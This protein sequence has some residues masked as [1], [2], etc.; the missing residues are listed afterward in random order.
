[1]MALAALVLSKMA[2]VGVP[3]LLKELVDQLGTAPGVLPIALLAGYGALRLTAAAFN[4]IRDALFA[5]VR[6]RAMRQVSLRVL[7]HLHTLGLRYHLERRTGA[8]IHD[9]DQGTRSV[10]SLLN[11]L[12]F[13]ILPTLVEIVLVALILLRRYD[14][15]FAAVT[16]C[17]VLIYIA[18]TFATT[19]WRIPLRHKMNQLESAASSQAVDSLINYETVKY[20]GNEA[21]ELRRYDATLAQWEDA[22][23]LTQTSLGMLNAGQSGIIAVGVTVVMILAAQ[24]I[25][26][27]R[28]TLGDLILVNAFLIQLFIPLNFLGVVYSQFKHALADMEQMLRLLDHRPEIAEAP[29]AIT[30]PDGALSIK[31]ESVAFAYLSERPILYDIDFSIPVGSK[32]AVVGASGSGKSTLARLLFRFYDVQS[33]RISIN[34]IDIRDL[35][36]ESLRAA[37]AIVPQDTVLFNETIYYNIAYGRPNATRVEIEHAAKLAHLQDFV[38]T[39]P[40]GYETIVGERGLKLSGGEKQRVAIARAILK[41]PRILIF[42]EATSSLD[43]HSEQIILTALAEVATQRTTL[44]IAHRLSTIM[45]ADQILVMDAGRITERGTHSELLARGGLYAYLWNLQQEERKP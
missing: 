35:Q 38:L 18:F 37:I 4:E 9:I 43:S 25:N 14:P 7:S 10:S 12:A 41:S 20:F 42:D 39:L 26:S 13:S 24:G 2:N 31:F 5:R 11:Y 40:Q 15:E 17:A 1:M 8:L 3:L 45:D 36:Q 30:L 22:A 6:H 19:N 21:H 34:G 33:G 28:M 44:V 29:N 16:C 27:G 23:V 32:I